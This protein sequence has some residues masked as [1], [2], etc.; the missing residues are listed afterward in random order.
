[1]HKICSRTVSLQIYGLEMRFVSLGYEGHA[2]CG[3]LIPCMVD[4][5]SKGEN[6][7]SAPTIVIQGCMQL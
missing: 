6:R 4:N 5:E 3:P 2:Q 1:M 7:P